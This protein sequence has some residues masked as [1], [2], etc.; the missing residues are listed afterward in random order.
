MVNGQKFAFQAELFQF[1]NH[2]IHVFKLAPGSKTCQGCNFYKMIIENHNIKKISGGPPV[3]SDK[4]DNRP[5]YRITNILIFNGI[6]KL[7]RG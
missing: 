7:K 2:C 6:H 3:V 4:Y 1:G 5:C